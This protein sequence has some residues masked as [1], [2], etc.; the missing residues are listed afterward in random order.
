MVETSP[1]GAGGEGARIPCL[2][3]RK[4]KHKNIVTNSIETLKVVHIK[5]KKKKNL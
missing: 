1:S 2:T 5:K 3:A 4:P